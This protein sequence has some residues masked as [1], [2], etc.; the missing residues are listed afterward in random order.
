MK[1]ASAIE[2]SARKPFGATVVHNGCYFAVWAP[3][4]ESVYVHLFDKQDGELSCFKLTEKKDGI[5]TG[6]AKGVKSGTCYALEA[7]GNSDPQQGTYFRKG[8]FLVDP[9]ALVLSKPF[10]FD[11]YLYEHNSA[12]FIPKA[13]I[14]DNPDDFDWQDV[15][16]PQL[17]VSSLI[18]YELNVKS[19]SK[20]CPFVPEKYRGTF[21]AL[22]QRKVI[23]HLKK[24][25]VNAVQL[26]PVAAS[27][28]EPELV[29]RGLSNLWGYNPVCFMAP[30]P[31]F[32][33]NPFEIRNE[34]RT[35]VR[36]LHRNGI[37]VILDVVFNHTAEGGI[38]GPVLSYKGLDNKSYYAFRRTD[39]GVDYTDYINVTG[40]GNSFNTDSMIGVNLV[41]DSLLYW[42]KIMRVDGFRFDLCVT[43]CRETHGNTFFE[44]ERNAGF[45]KSCF[46]HDSLASSVMI[47]EPWD[48]GPR[49]YHLGKFPM[50]W[51]EQNDLFRD[52]VRRFWRGDDSSLGNFATRLMGSRDVFLK[53][54]RPVNASLNYVTY[55]DGF[56]LED[57]VSYSRKYNENNGKENADGTWENYSYNCGAEGKTSN[58]A[59]LER[60]WQLKRNLIATLFLS[61][62]TPHFLAGDEFSRTQLGNNNA[63]CQDNEISYIKWDY[64]K[65]NKDFIEFIHRCTKL[66]ANSMLLSEIRLADDDYHING[67]TSSVQWFSPDG[68]PMSPE[69]WNN[70]KQKALLVFASGTCFEHNEDCCILINNTDTELLFKLVTPPKR[71]HWSV[72]LDTSIPDGKP[73]DICESG[74]YECTCKAFSIKVFVAIAS[75]EMEK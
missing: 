25:G 62:G 1:K 24:L 33:C 27:M 59:V 43:L 21:L 11:K 36:E 56:T 60:R 28:T 57:L 69:R 30:D 7:L 42:S 73:Q 70:P 72:S 66:R 68:T 38:D 20:L 48:I 16:R 29:E 64:C 63:F 67:H 13:V 34:F 10:N 3:E 2:D 52:T 46:C 19:F 39:K 65:K 22:S 45:L 58:R 41:I 5:W 31:R 44:F 4:A 50:G 54:H 6:F 53:G 8:R 14:E 61:Q 15:N 17:S 32:A 26:N 71:K 47:A 75:K 51:L 9:Y 74:D 35:M 18:V 37:G 49:G 23:E 12:S 40:C 55:H